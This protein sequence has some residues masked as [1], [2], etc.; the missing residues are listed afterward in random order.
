[1][2][3]LDAGAYTGVFGVTEVPGIPV[4]ATFRLLDGG[5]DDRLIASVYVVPF[6]G[7]E[8]C[9]V[10]GFGDGAWTVPGGTVEPG[11]H[12]AAALERELVEE[13]GAR[14]CGGYTPFAVL[15]CHSRAPAPYRPH[16]P[17]P[18]YHCL[19]GYGQ[20]ELVTAPTPPVGGGERITAV[21]VMP[22]DDCV[23]F[24]A[25]AATPWDR[26]L[27]RLAIDLRRRRQAAPRPDAP[28]A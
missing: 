7:P 17:H 4:D 12:W 22:A 3:D 18:D 9:V 23:A 15:A 27:Y 1:M 25:G 26:D 20:V 2:T 10:V 8:A 11:E 19:Y 13:A 16:L 28:R 14:L 21:E 5:V 6:I 24:L